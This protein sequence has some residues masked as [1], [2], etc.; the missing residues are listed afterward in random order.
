MDLSVGETL[1]FEDIT[2]LGLTYEIVDK[3]KFRDS[4]EM[5]AICFMHKITHIVTPCGHYVL[6][7]NESCIAVAQLRCPICR[8]TTNGKAIKV[9]K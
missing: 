3:E 9:Y 8:R 5:C 4:N 2:H 6:C 7:D 1:E